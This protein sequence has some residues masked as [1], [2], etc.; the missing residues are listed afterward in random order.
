MSIEKSKEAI[1]EKIVAESHE[2]SLQIRAIPQKFNGS[3]NTG[4]SLLI[5]RYIS[6]RFQ[7]IFSSPIIGDINFGGQICE[8]VEMDVY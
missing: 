4:F 6:L 2:L 7:V 8:I 3:L 5:M 1:L